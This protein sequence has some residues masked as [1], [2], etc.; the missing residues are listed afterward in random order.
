M[1]FYKDGNINEFPNRSNVGSCY[2]WS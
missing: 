2:N 1:K